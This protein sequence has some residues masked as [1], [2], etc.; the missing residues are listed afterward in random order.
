MSESA[1]TRNRKQ[2]TARIAECA[3]SLAEQRGL[4]GFTMEDVAK[5]AGVSR[6][7]LFNHVS[8]KLDAV[9]GA[10]PAPDPANL[11]AFRAGG[12][13]GHLADDV[14]ATI[15]AV[16]ESKDTTPGEWERVR[17]LIA[18][19]ARLYKAMH[20]KFARLADFLAEA[21]R[22]REPERFGAL[23][24]KAAATVT[25][26]LFDVALEAVVADPSRTLAEYFIDAFDGVATLFD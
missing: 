9:L 11:I 24:A 6:R 12:P 22:E 7:T 25:L 26:S 18:S 17:A 21:I 5:C 3:Q 1:T 4:D 2:T 10:P 15:A 19:D 20:D 13:T 8:G 14:K 23:S 16:L